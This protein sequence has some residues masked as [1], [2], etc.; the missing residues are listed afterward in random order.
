MSNKH[1]VNLKNRLDTLKLSIEWLKRSYEQC[2]AIGIKEIYTKDEFDKFENLT[3]R[4]ARTLVNQVMRGL[5]AVELL[6]YGTIIDMLN[7]AEKRGIVP[8][9]DILRDLKDLRNE[10]A[11]EYQIDNIEQFFDLVLTST[12]ILLSIIDNTFDYARQYTS[13]I[14]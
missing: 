1:I 11:H 2:G 14:H 12:P 7:R 3:S 10:I 9:A 8:T 5:D 6:N 13:D 4:Y